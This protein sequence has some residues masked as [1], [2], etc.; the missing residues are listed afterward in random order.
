VSD[1]QVRPDTPLNGTGSQ[2]LAALGARLSASGHTTEQVQ[3][4]I[5]RIRSVAEHVTVATLNET[6]EDIHGAQQARINRLVELVMLLPAMA[7][8]VR[9]DAVLLAIKTAFYENQ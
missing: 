4:V 8:H 5:S 2:E 7:G 9:R 6:L 3:K 1:V